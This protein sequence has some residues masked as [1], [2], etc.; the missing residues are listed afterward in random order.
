MILN[1]LFWLG[2]M[3]HK[4]WIDYNGPKGYW[5]VKR[6]RWWKSK[7]TRMYQYRKYE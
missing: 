1:P 3:S 4:E 7:W 2:I 6:F 5:S